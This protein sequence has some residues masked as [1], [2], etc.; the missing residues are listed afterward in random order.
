MI[1]LLLKPLKSKVFLFIGIAGVVAISFTTLYFKYLHT[2]IDTLNLENA[3]HES[4]I[5]FY[6]DSILDMYD[7]SV[8]IQNSLNN[9]IDA[10]EKASTSYMDTEKR[11]RE[12]RESN[13]KAM[14]ATKE[15]SLR[16]RC[17]ELYTGSLIQDGEDN[18]LCPELFQ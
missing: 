7:K 12:L 11:L 4:L 15:F 8:K 10:H 2:K 17:L 3:Q 13:D 16:Y 1:P 5:S 6:E 9:V 18:E 14:E